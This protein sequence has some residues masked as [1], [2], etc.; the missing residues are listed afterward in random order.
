MENNYIQVEGL[1]KGEVRKNFN[2][3]FNKLYSEY[4][5]NIDKT[6]KQKEEAENDLEEAKQILNNVNDEKN[7]LNKELEKAK[8]INI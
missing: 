1:T 4:R 8:N 2:E 6:I 7:E 3:A 5:F